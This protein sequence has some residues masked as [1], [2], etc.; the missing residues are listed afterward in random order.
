MG[1]LLKTRYLQTGTRTKTS[2]SFHNWRIQNARRRLC[3]AIAGN[4]RSVITGTMTQHQQTSVNVQ[5]GQGASA[6]Y[7]LDH[8]ITVVLN[9]FD[10]L[11]NKGL[12]FIGL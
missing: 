12:K 1:P 4:I 3:R 5:S 7:M 9:I 11:K 6:G 2:S 10:T 8:P